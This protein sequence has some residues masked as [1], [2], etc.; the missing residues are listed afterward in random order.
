MNKYYAGIGSRET[1][2][3]LEPIIKDI[4]ERCEYLGYTLRSGGAAGADSMFSNYTTRKNIYLPWSNYNGNRKTID[5]DKY[6]EEA[7][8]IAAM[9]HP[10]WD[11]CS[12]GAKLLHSRNSHIILGTDLLKPVDFVVCW[13][14]NG[15][16]QGGTGLAMRIANNYNIPIYNLKNEEDIEKLKLFIK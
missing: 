16:I 9:F 6:L 5:T 14:K 7:L 4:V 15:K 8:G 12:D 3:S 10:N 1:P 11:A 13:T 2:Y